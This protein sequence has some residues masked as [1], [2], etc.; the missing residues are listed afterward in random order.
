MVICELK[1]IKKFPKLIKIISKSIAGSDFEFMFFLDFVGNCLDA[2]VTA[3]LDD[4]KKE[5]NSF[6]LLGNF[7][8]M[9]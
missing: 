4:L 3:L 5:M 1:T 2:K 9:L 7:K 8:E 6:R